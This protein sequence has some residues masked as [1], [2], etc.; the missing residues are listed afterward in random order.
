M[1]IQN[2]IR[3]LGGKMLVSANRHDYVS[4]EENGNV[5]ATDGGIDYLRRT[6]P[7]SDLSVWDKVLN[8]FGWYKDKLLPDDFT[9]EDDMLFSVV[10]ERLLRGTNGKHGDE[11]FHFVILKDMDTEWV[12]AA[13]KYNKKYN[14][15]DS[16]A[17]DM[18]R[19]EL[20]FRGE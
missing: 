11:D 18:Y 14:K 17:S 6:Y 5:Y 7:M 12:K 16:F 10:R 8:F 4:V 20:E 15:D 2:A 13:I 1:I 3:T 9:V 19:K